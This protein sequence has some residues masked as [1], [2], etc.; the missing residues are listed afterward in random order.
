MFW[1]N[2]KVDFVWAV[3]YLLLTSS[4]QLTVL[5]YAKE[6]HDNNVYQ[7]CPFE[8]RLVVQHQM[9]TRIELFVSR[10]VD[11]LHLEGQSTVL[12]TADHAT[13]LGFADPSTLFDSCLAPIAVDFVDGHFELS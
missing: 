7:L 6:L 5:K 13:V 3:D 9:R 11:C 12:G 1:V 8:D 10:I 4:G 2:K